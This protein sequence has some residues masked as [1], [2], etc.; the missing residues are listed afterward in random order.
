MTGLSAGI[1][2]TAIEGLITGKVYILSKLSP[3]HYESGISGVILAASYLVF[4]VGLVFG[5]MGVL[6]T[7]KGDMYMSWL[8]NAAI[9][10]GIILL[11]ALFAHFSARTVA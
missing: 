9:L 7:E 8:K 3:G 10:A 1:G 4:S 5:A 2:Y 6:S 11:G